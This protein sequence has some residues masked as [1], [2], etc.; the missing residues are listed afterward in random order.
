[1]EEVFASDLGWKFRSEIIPWVRSLQDDPSPE[2]I[3]PTDPWT[4][5]HIMEAVEKGW[6]PGDPPIVI[7][8]QP[9]CYYG[10]R[11]VQM[12]RDGSC[13]VQIPHVIK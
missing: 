3:E 10:H 4:E 5:K 1:M 9:V 12:N 11:V 6:R 2:P 13:S 8:P 7:P